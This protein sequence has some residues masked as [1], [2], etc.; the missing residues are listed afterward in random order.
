V[1][2]VGNIGKA[3]VRR[4]RA[5]GMTVLGCD[6]APVPESFLNETKLKLVALG[7]LLAESDFISLNCDL[8][9][10]SFHLIGRDELASMRPTAYLIN[11][12]RGALIDEGALVEALDARSI[13]GAA[14][15]VFEHEPLPAESPLRAFDNCLLA[16]HNANNSRA[17]RTRVHESTIANLLRALREGE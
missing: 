14:L 7:A 13:A 6:P 5:F 16:P 1:I 3:V 9:P 12:A 4:A 11:T 17:A 8:N 10:S 15:D 2:G